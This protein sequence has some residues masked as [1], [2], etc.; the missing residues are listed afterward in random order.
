MDVSK[1]VNFTS[2]WNCVQ[3]R[4]KNFYYKQKDTFDSI[5]IDLI[6]F[7]VN[8]I[9]NC[10]HQKLLKNQLWGGDV[11][12]SSTRS[13]GCQRQCVMGTL[14][15]RKIWYTLQYSIN[16]RSRQGWHTV[17]QYGCISETIPFTVDYAAFIWIISLTV[18]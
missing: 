3:K 7:C 1:K 12:Q 13:F 5:F 14:V 6:Y 15:K 11:F 16:V 17:A 10:Q 18:L 9:Q 2:T 8:K 4:T